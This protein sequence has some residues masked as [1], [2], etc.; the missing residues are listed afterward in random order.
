[1]GLADWFNKF[2]S[3]LKITDGGT[4][5][6]RY[7]NIT[8]RLNTDFWNTTS[9]TAHSIY[10]GSYGRNTA[11]QGMSDLDMIFQLPYSIYEKYNN[12]SSNG[13]SALLQEVKRSIE[14]TYSTT[15][16]RA[17]GQVIVV[18]FDDGISFE[19]VPAFINN[20]NS[21]TFPNA[22]NGGSW[23]K[24]NPKPEI[25][26]IQDRNSECNNNLVTLCRMLRSWKRKW[27]VPI[28]GLLIDTLVYQFI[29][30]Y[31]FRDK[32]F[33]Y[34]DYFCRDLFKWMSEQDSEQ[35]YW[36]A[37]G[38]GQNVYGKGLFQYKAKRCY[39]LSLEAI[40]H[41][42]ANPQEEWSAKQ[43]WREIFGTQYPD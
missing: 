36:R 4:I 11:I 17:D 23:S 37:P 25:K 21:F 41:E 34:Y 16:I 9:E 18:P 5:S 43:K 13:Q 38:S 42:T 8:K 10:V 7:N 32:S 30:N 39:N 3:N 22:N 28:G 29:E 33:I 19:T 1:M 14:K 2:H 35:S 6:L 12:Y 31:E 27:D 15:S 24:T 26:A 40:K 20:D